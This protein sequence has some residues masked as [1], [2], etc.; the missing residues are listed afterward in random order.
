MYTKPTAPRNIG[1]VLDSTFSLW[2]SVIKK[3]WLLAI[4]PQLLSMSGVVYE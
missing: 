1:G 2:P 4:I 3:T